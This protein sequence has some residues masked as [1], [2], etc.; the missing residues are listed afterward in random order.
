M[1]SVKRCA[2]CGFKFS[3][4]GKC[5]SDACAERAVREAIKQLKEKKGP[6]YDRWKER[7]KESL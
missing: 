2:G 7:L 4:S 6:I 3:G 1:A 5:C